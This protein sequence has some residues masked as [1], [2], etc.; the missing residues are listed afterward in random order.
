MSKKKSKSKLNNLVKK[1]MEEL[2]KP[3]T[4]KDKK[5]EDKRNPS[6][7]WDEY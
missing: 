1:Y 7:T 6:S 5:K 2:H 3:V 4:H